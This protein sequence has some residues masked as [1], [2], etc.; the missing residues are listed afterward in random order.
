MVRMCFIKEAIKFCLACYRE[1]HCLGV[2]GKCNGLCGEDDSY[3]MV[4]ALTIGL[5][6]SPKFT[7]SSTPRRESSPQG[8][9]KRLYSYRI[10]S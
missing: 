10:Q 3:H 8:L 7:P 5:K 6:V 4:D 9:N 2:V 1:K